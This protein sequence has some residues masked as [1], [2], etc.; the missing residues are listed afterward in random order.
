MDTPDQQ[1][2]LVNS[3]K[4]CLGCGYSLAGLTRIGKCPECGWDVERSLEGNRLRNCDRA[5]LRKLNRG[6][7]LILL[8]MVVYVMWIGVQIVVATNFKV[9]ALGLAVLSAAGLT[10]GGI[11]LAGWWLVSWPDHSLIGED[12]AIG[13][14]RVLRLLIMASMCGLVAASGAWIL[15]DGG[16]GRTRGIG[17]SW[18]N[19]LWGGAALFLIVWPFKTNVALQYVRR[20]ARRIPDQAIDERAAFLIRFAVVGAVAFVVVVPVVVILNDVLRGLVSCMIGVVLVCGGGAIMG[21]WAAFLGL[22]IDL[23][24]AIWIVIEDQKPATGATSPPADVTSDRS[25]HVSS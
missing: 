6:V 16:S 5:Y 4:R 19:V 2:V 21:W 8:S 14:R 3:E 12:P 7:G 25:G 24:R 18:W 13:A 17:S 20:L 1:I 11:N 10:A 22:V 9:H 15:F 23:R